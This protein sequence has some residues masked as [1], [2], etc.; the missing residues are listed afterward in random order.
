MQMHCAA[1]VRACQ[2]LH[3]DEMPETYLEMR[4]WS[5]H[6]MMSTDMLA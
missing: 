2:A 1:S 6:V 4:W 5:L 3:V